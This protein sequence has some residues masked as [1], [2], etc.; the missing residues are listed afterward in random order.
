MMCDSP[1]VACPGVR[2]AVRICKPSKWPCKA[3]DISMLCCSTGE[4]VRWAHITICLRGLSFINSYKYLDILLCK[5]TIYYQNLKRMLWSE[6]RNAVS[7]HV[8]KTV[9]EYGD[10]AGGGSEDVDERCR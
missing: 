10:G 1:M 2:S 7:H 9:D 4:V 5:Y 8:D 6:P 3:G